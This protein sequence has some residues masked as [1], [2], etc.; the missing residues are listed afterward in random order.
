MTINSFKLVQELI[1][2]NGHYPGDPEPV[3]AI[4]RYETKWGGSAYHLAYKLRDIERLFAPDSM[5][6]NPVLIWQR[7]GGASH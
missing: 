4:H 3:I 2:A 6:H 7:R 5:A 1:A